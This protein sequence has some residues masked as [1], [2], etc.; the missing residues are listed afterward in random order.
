MTREDKAGPKTAAG[1]LLLVSLSAAGALAVLWSTPKGVELDPDSIRYVAVARN[2]LAGRGFYVPYGIAGPLP[3]THWPPLYPASLAV[4]GFFGVDPLAGARLLNAILLGVNIL[5][6]GVTVRRITAPKMWPAVAAAA[7]ALSSVDMLSVHAT[8][9][10]EPLFIAL[11]LT[12]VLLLDR[13]LQTSAVRYLVLSGATGALVLL[14]RYHGIAF[15]AAAAAALVVL[16]KRGLSRRLGDAAVFGGMSLAPIALWLV[17]NNIVAGN[18]F[19]RPV[20]WHPPTGVLVTEALN[21][22]TL[23]AAP[24]MVPLAMRCVWLVAVAAAVTAC[25]FIRAGARDA[26]YRDQP[27]GPEAAARRILATYYMYAVLYVALLAVSLTFFDA[28]TRLDARIL[29]PFYVAMLIPAAYAVKRIAGLAAKRLSAV[30]IGVLVGALLVASA[31]RGYAAAAAVHKA[32]LDPARKTWRTYALFRRAAALP[33]AA[34]LVSNSPGAVY[35]LTERKV[36]A[37]PQPFDQHA[38]SRNPNYEVEMAKT[39]DILKRGAYVVYFTVEHQI[40]YMPTQ[41]ELI[42]RLDL[43]PV[44]AEAEGVIYATR[45]PARDA[46]SLESGTRGGR[47]PRAQ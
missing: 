29:L 36:Y 23:W 14:A 42:Q 28:A 9:W 19:D 1:V 18:P 31:V 43:V 21:T 8:A 7:V 16:G 5:L 41:E 22:S 46:T 15:V 34:E 24:A 37:L 39:L 17:R 44:A 12:A 30:I 25:C 3:F 40:W 26:G 11:C 4:L 13:Y 2:L 45:P 47:T 32:R 33:P 35:L 27:A 10:S 38:M 20:A 6:V